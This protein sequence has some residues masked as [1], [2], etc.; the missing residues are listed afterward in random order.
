[1]GLTTCRACGIHA[2]QR[3]WARSVGWCPACG[4]SMV[5]TPLLRTLPAEQRRAA[6]VGAASQTTNPGQRTLGPIGGERPRSLPPEPHSCW[7]R[8]RSSSSS[9]RRSGRREASQRRPGRPGHPDG[10][11]PVSP[12]RT[13]SGRPRPSSIRRRPPASAAPGSRRRTATWR[14]TGRRRPRNP[15]APRRH[16]RERP[17]PRPRRRRNRARSPRRSPRRRR[18]PRLDAGTPT[19]CVAVGAGSRRP[20]P[21]HGGRSGARPGSPEPSPPSTATGT[22]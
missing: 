2:C 16:R 14:E 21:G 1:M 8:R 11:S 4:V 10:L 18:T 15:T 9:G 19:P 5:A 7:R 17:R 3:C 20:A 22:T 6:T 12:R 13:R